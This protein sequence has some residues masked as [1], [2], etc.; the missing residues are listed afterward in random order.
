MPLRVGSLCALA[1]M[2]IKEVGFRRIGNAGSFIQSNELVSRAG[3]DDLA[4]KGSFQ[5]SLQLLSN[6]QSD[7]L[8]CDMI[9]AYGARVSSP[10]SGIDHNELDPEGKLPCQTGERG[11]MFRGCW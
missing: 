11:K 6:G 5:A 1:C 2:E 3:E 8:F 10:V 4:S 9:T 7:I